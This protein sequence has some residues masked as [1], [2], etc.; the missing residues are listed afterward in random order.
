TALVGGVLGFDTDDKRIP[1]ALEIAKNEGMEITLS[2]DTTAS[3][4]PNTARLLIGDQVD[5]LEIFG[6][7]IGGGKAEIK[8]INGFRLRLSG[9]HPAILVMHDDRAGA[10]ASVTDILAVHHINIGHMEVNRKDVGTEAL[11]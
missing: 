1:N 5:K 8:E 2:E 6:I 9:N 3:D 11:M 10:I 4:H 7:S